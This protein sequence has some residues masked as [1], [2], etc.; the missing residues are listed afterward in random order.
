MNTEPQTKPYASGLHPCPP[1]IFDLP[2]SLVAASAPPRPSVVKNRLTTIGDTLPGITPVKVTN[3]ST[4]RK[5]YA[6][7]NKTQG[8]EQADATGERGTLKTLV[9]SI[10]ARR[11][12]IQYA[13]D[14]EWQHTD[15]ANAGLRRAFFLPMNKTLNR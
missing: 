1:V 15:K 8:D 13:A 14:P 9:E 10:T 5:G 7:G 11:I 3:L 12:R 6:D 2:S 4:P